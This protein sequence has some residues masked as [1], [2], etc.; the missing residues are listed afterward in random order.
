RSPPS[1]APPHQARDRSPSWP[2]DPLHRAAARS[3]RAAPA[4]RGPWHAVQLGWKRRAAQVRNFARPLGSGNSPSSAPHVPQEP[5]RAGRASPPIA[6]LLAL[7]VRPAGAESAACSLNMPEREPPSASAEPRLGVACAV[8]PGFGVPAEFSAAVT[9]RSP[10]PC[11]ATSPPRAKGKARTPRSPIEASPP[12]AKEAEVRTAVPLFGPG[13][14]TLFGFDAPTSPPKK[15]SVPV[16]VRILTLGS[17]PAA[18]AARIARTTSWCRKSLGR[19][20]I[21]IHRPP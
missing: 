4:A 10:F 8:P 21:A 13:S 20:T 6:A 19:L 5:G 11:I 16:G 2:P 1:P 18:R 3:R 14:G 7:A 17:I 12:F 9:V 15:Y